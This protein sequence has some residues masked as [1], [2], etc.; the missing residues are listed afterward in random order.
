[1][2]FERPIP[3]Q[4]LT[5]EPKNV[6]YEN[7]PELVD[8]EEAA[9]VHLERINNAEA[10]ESILFFLENGISVVA[11][12]E[13]LLRTAV[14]A[15][16]HSIDVSLIIGPIIHEFIKSAADAAGIEYD[17]G[18]EDRKGKAAVRYDRESL[19]AKKILQKMDI[20]PEETVEEIKEP[21]KTTIDEEV[22]PI[23]KPPAGL[24]ARTEV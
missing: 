11:V 2:I 4:S 1:M 18:L 23:D 12:T 17:E 10:V 22:E 7:P 5:T 16:V 6:P 9:L 13:G 20:D 19:R 8:P 14:L 15:G 24:M 21:E 3:G